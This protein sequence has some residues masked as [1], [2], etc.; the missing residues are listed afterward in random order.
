L[1]NS[2]VT[3]QGFYCDRDEID[4]NPNDMLGVQVLAATSPAATISTD[5]DL[6][7]VSGR[8]NTTTGDGK[9][10]QLALQP[11]ASVFQHVID[12]ANQKLAEQAATGVIGRFSLEVLDNTGNVL[13]SVP[14]SVD[15]TIE[16]G[17]ELDDKW[18]AFVELLEFPVGASTAI[19]VDTQSGDTLAMRTR[20]AAVPAV[21]FTSLA[22]G[23][24]LDA[25]E[26]ISWSGSDGDGDDLR[27]TLRYSPDGV[28]W[29]VI[30]LDE[31]ESDRLLTSIDNLPGSTAGSVEVVASDGFNTTT[32]V[33]NG[34]IVPGKAP[35]IM[36]QSPEQDSV[37]TDDMPIVFVAFAQD[38][39]D[40]LI[41]SELIEWSSDISGSLGNGGELFIAPAGIPSGPHRITAS[42]TD[43][44]GMS[45]NASVDISFDD[46]VIQ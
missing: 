18:F 40:G 4:V 11:A 23:A 1:L 39:E 26:T 13:Y 35:R 5:G 28:S 41:D 16:E 29:Y 24:V 2:Y 37:V 12:D 17:I 21:R 42:V 20:S 6:L 36:I 44:S 33:F 7:L 46:S 30:A 9:I 32:D 25:G 27:Y 15:E 34:V 10:M 45:A 43:S 31:P 19:L 3:T 14:I 38:T 8:V 22:P